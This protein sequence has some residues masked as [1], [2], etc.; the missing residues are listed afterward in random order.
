MSALKAEISTE[1]AIVTANCWYMRPVIPGMAA[2]G[3]KT[4]AR[5]SAMATTGPP[6]S[7]MAFSVAD[8]GSIP[9]SIWCSTASTTMMASS[10]TRPM[11]ST[12][13]N[14]DSVLI[15]NPSAGKMINVPM[16]E[17]GTASRGMSVARQPCRKMKTTITTRPSASKSVRQYLANASSDG[18]GG[19][20]RDTVRDA[21]RKRRGKLLHALH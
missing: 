2:V 1:I 14:S 15:E 12:R 21:R 19:I 13:P 16:S 4:A 11:A 3:M 18:L 10:T 20:Q 9:S 8:L 6:T 7:S 17:T 5:I